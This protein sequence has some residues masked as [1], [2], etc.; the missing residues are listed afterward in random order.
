M[1]NKKNIFLWTLYDFANSIIVIVFYIYFAQWF[2]IDRNISGFLYN[3]LFV[4][5]TILVIIFAPILGIIADRNKLNFLFLKITTI[6]IYILFLF[7]A[8]LIN[9]KPEFIVFI[10]IIYIL[11]NAIYQISFSFY[12]PL[13]N[14]LSTEKNKGQI[15]GIGHMAG[16]LGQIFGILISLYFLN[17]LFIFNSPGRTQTFLPST[18]IFI[19]LS[20]P[21]L[22]LFKDKKSKK[23]ENKRFSYKENVIE[24]LKEFKIIWNIPNLKFFF[25]SFF[26]FNDAILTASNN[27]PLYLQEVFGVSDKIK[28]LLMVGILITAALGSIVGGYIG[29]KIG[30]KKTNLILLGFWIIILPSF[31]FTNNFIVFSFISIIMGFVFGATNSVSRAL[32]SKILS[33]NNNSSFGFGLYSISERVASLLGPITWGII[34]ILPFKRALNYRVAI[35]SMTIFVIIGFYYMKKVSE[36]R[37]VT[38]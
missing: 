33:Y 4:G 5:S 34:L 10:S 8:F 37:Y 21:M 7:I 32:L 15:S 16:W 20:L 27:F 31:G 23:K 22:L 36:K 3:M 25:I 14:D 28:S 19:I 2:T 17:I 9:L 6:V 11:G 26:F 1:Q 38:Q 12:N 24:I 18:I 13:I 29:D 30:L 35:I